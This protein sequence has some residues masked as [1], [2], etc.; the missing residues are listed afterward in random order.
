MK[1]LFG[2]F[3]SK[4]TLAMLCCFL[5]VGF[6]LTLLIQQL[7]LSYQNEVEQ[8]LH[9]ELAAKIV[10]ENPVIK[11]GR[12]DHEALKHAFHST[13]VLGPSFEFYL[14]DTQGNIQTYSAEPGKVKRDSVNLAPIQHFISGTKVLPIL[15]DDP[16]SNS[17]KKIFSVAE[18]QN[19][20]N[21]EP[22][23]GYLYIIIGGEIYDGV[24]D[25]LKSSHI[26]KLSTGNLVLALCFMLLVM[27][28]MFAMLTRP[29]R[30]LT[31]DMLLLA[32]N[33]FEPVAQ[34][35][36]NENWDKDSSDEIQKL[37]ST[38][39][40]MTQVLQQQYQKVKDTEEL[41]KELISYVS[42]DLRTPL[43]SLQGYLETWQL[44]KN[45]LTQE[46]SDQLIAVALKNARQMS[47]LVEQLFELAHLDSDTATMNM[48]PVAIAEL[49]QDVI[50][51]L[52]LDAQQKQVQVEIKPKDPS[53]LVKAD[54]AKME[55]VLTNLID[56]AIRHSSQG[57]QVCVAVEA[58]PE[59]PSQL[60]ISV[61]D[62]GTGI[63]ADEVEL[64][65]DPHFR[66]SNSQ[67]GKGINSG[68]GLAITKRIVELHGSSIGVTSELGQGTS[69]AFKLEKC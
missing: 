38:F 62:T 7:T 67:K 5:L 8:K 28:L 49:A 68:L 57:D 50:T 26:A 14:L 24:V 37:G 55:R 17:R 58:V 47:G 46:Q 4:L 41:R 30:R 56:N 18:I 35:S 1:S 15:G 13:M 51:N 60:L 21:G 59:D 45:N 27:L 43:A 61:R 10:K 25:L 65:F 3:Y 44:Q 36:L 22:L 63:P 66:A 48:E 42:H 52:E 2:T 19:K 33:G 40:S 9:L 23:V 20:E 6:G 12:I 11:E 54:I 31:R 53:I 34:S 39:T 16:R 64:I 29:L 32:K 69:F